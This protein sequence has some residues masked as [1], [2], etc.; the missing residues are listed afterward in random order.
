MAQVPRFS[1]SDIS[2][3][4]RKRNPWLGWGPPVSSSG[5][6]SELRPRA[7]PLSSG[8]TPPCISVYGDSFTYGYGAEDAETYPHYLSA[9]LECP[10]ANYG[11]DGYGSDQAFML[12]RAQEHLDDAPLVILGHLSENI[13]R[14]VNR[15]RALLYPGSAF[16]FKP[17]FV[18]SNRG[19]DYVPIPVNNVHDFRALQAE[20]DSVLS[21]DALLTRPR[22]SFPFTNALLRWSI[23]DFKL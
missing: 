9:M 15:Y 18:T 4:L 2:R 14:N 17:R 20:P 19:L 1:E 11:V 23:S 21:G 5:K 7:D 6:V 12:F 13:L 3:Y 22:R 10:V 16:E 8:S